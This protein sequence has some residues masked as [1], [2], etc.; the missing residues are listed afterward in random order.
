MDPLLRP[1][2]AGFVDLAVAGPGL[3]LDMRY[4]SASNFTGAP[5]PGYGAHGAWLR[6]EVAG[7]LVRAQQALAGQGFDLGV[8]D[9]YR[10][11]RATRAM[12]A[13]AQRAGRDELLRGYISATSRH[14]RGTAVD[15]GLWRGG[16][17]VDMGC[18]FDHFADAAHVHHA[19]GAFL[20]ARLALRAAMEAEGFKPYDREWWHFERPVEGAEPQDVPYGLQEPDLG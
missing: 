8:Y 6:A 12:V 4:H 2:P 3:V 14:N 7:A 19:A 13:W 9:A 17:E 18:P 5:L 15:V 16:A 11:A 10:P 1:A 20:A